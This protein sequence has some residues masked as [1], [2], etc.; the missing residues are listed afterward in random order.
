M[1]PQYY[2]PSGY[3]VFV[4]LMKNILNM[5]LTKCDKNKHYVPNRD[6]FKVDNIIYIAIYS[7]SM[8]MFG[9]L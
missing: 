7:T 4:L 3:Y 5:L 2:V 6:N 8:A 9:I 1:Q